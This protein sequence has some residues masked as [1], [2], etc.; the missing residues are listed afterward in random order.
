MDTERKEGFL[1]F[2]GCVQQYL[3][4]PVGTVGQELIKL[5]TKLSLGHIPLQRKAIVRIPY[6]F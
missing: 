3:L 1:L 2:P 5:V 4:S 6:P